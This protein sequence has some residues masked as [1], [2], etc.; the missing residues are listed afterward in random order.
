MK[1]LII[2]IFCFVVAFITTAQSQTDKTN[3]K[4][5]NG[6]NLKAFQP[7]SIE[8]PDISSHPMDEFFI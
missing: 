4:I 5:S 2:P 8:V 1:K 6:L 7:K 3:D